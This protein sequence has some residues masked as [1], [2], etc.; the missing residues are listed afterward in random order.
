MIDRHKTI[1]R[2][3]YTA[4]C[5]GQHIVQGE[6]FDFYAELPGNHSPK[7]A[8]KRLRREFGD[9]SIVI[10]NVEMEARRY[11]MPLETFIENAKEL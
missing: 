9:E 2:T 5:S 10:N 3:I 7:S 4:K 8:T 6:F 1:T 11:S